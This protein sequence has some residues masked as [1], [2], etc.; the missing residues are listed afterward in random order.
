MFSERIYWLIS[1]N[2]CLKQ[3]FRFQSWNGS[4]IWPRFYTLSYFF[5]FLNG[6]KLFFNYIYLFSLM[7]P[8]IKLDK[9]H[10][11][12]QDQEMSLTWNVIC[13]S[14]MFL[15]IFKV[16]GNLFLC[17]FCVQLAALLLPHREKSTIDVPHIIDRS[18]IDN[19]KC[20]NVWRWKYQGIIQQ[21]L[22]QAS[23]RP[24]AEKSE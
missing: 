3:I 14:E 21:R 2:L 10:I 22:V 19:F 5:Q 8:L 4:K 23:E 7:N 18:T 17:K 24:N 6:S 11:Y 16:K 20:C 15:N 1:S 13:K 12:I 9:L